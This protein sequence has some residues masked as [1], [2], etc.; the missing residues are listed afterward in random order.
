MTNETPPLRKRRWFPY[1]AGGIAGTAVAVV[2]LA[3]T[4]GTPGG[5]PSGSA[6]VTAARAPAVAGKAR[7][8]EHTSELQSRQYLV[9]RL[10]LEKK[11]HSRRSQ[12]DRGRSPVILRGPATTWHKAPCAGIHGFELFAIGGT[13]DHALRRRS[14]T[15]QDRR[16]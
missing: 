14:P 8:E 3:V 4:G 10:L 15:T 12:H 5:S 13:G 16:L 7:S 11:K 9:C 2:A 1:T 6:A